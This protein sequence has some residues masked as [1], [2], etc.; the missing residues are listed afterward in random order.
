MMF[1]LSYALEDDL[2]HRGHRWAEE[3]KPNAFADFKP[4]SESNIDMGV[5]LVFLATLAGN[6]E[7]LTKHQKK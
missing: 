6:T 1:R 4:K 7:F 5:F 2:V 3:Q